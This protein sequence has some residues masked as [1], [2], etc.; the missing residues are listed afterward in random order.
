MADDDLFPGVDWGARAEKSPGAGEKAGAKQRR[1]A[2]KRMLYMIGKYGPAPEGGSCATRKHLIHGGTSHRRSYL[3]CALYG[4]SSS[5][6]T[7]WRK[8]WEGCGA[9]NREGLT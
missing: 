6:S 8:K 9:Y 7:D 1:L 2:R 3:K 5:E 4:N